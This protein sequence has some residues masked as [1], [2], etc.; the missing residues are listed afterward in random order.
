[1][2]RK[3]NCGAEAAREVAG[4]GH[5]KYQDA[6]VDMIRTTS[7][8]SCEL[9]RYRVA[10]NGLPRSVLWRTIHRFADPTRGS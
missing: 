6:A 5:E 1:M 7:L 8:A 9:A 10:A 2:P 3:G 4:V